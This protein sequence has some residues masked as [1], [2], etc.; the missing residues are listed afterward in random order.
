MLLMNLSPNTSP[1]YQQQPQFNQFLQPQYQPVYNEIPNSDTNGVQYKIVNLK[2]KLEP[3]LGS[4]R[5]L[6]FVR[7]IYN[8]G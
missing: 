6:I 5:F 4:M 3:Q 8:Q 7:L 2:F 1:L